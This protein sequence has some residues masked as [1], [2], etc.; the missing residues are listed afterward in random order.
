[1]TTENTETVTGGALGK[2]A[3][4]AKETAGELLGRDDIAREGRLQQAGADADM[5]ARTLAEEARD[6]RA[7]ADLEARK[8]DNDAERTRLEA[9]AGAERREAQIEADADRAQA[10]ADLRE[11]EARRAEARADTID[12]E[13]QS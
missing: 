7:E 6:E 12:P 2:L 10:Q 9:E 4:R 13:E 8:A 5:E 3:G 1:M 11:A